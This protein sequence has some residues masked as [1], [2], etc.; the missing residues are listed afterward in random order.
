MRK[1]D[2]G[3]PAYP[4]ERMSAHGILAHTGLPEGDAEYIAAL[5]TMTHGMSL[6][7]WFA[8][9]ALPTAAADEERHPT[10]DEATY[11]GTA[12]RAY[13]YADAMLRAREGL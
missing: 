13:L 5:A 4:I 12:E 2:D 8:G 1:S 6:R 7:D 11:K 10:C 3:G 9:Q